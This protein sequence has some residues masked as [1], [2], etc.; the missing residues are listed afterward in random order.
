MLVKATTA[1]T[2]TAVDTN[3]GP[4]YANTSTSLGATYNTSDKTNIPAST[5]VKGSLCCESW[6]GTSR[7][8][9][10]EDEGMEGRDRKGV[11]LLMGMYAMH[12]M[13]DEGQ[14]REDW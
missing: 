13:C 14:K 5:A 6:D 11:L 1:T 4:K 10:G 12:V 8:I 9:T 7:A 3:R 2:S